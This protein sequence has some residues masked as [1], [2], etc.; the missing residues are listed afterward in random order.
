LTGRNLWIIDKNAPYTDPESGLSSGN[1]RG[2]Q[3]GASPSVKEYGFNIKMN[4]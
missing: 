2:N 1:I 4:F 3:S